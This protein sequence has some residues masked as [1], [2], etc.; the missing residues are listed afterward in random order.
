MHMRPRFIPILLSSLA[1]FMGLGLGGCEEVPVHSSLYLAI[2]SQ[3]AVDRLEIRVRTGAEGEWEVLG[4][5]ST[6]DLAIEDLGNKDLTTSPYIV[7]VDAS[8]GTG[9][10]LVHVVGW[11]GEQR[12]V[13]AQHLDLDEKT[14]VTVVLHSFSEEC[15]QD[16]D[17][18]LRCSLANCCGESW[19]SEE[20]SDCEDLTTLAHPFAETVCCEDADGDGFPD[21]DPA[22]DC[23][24]TAQTAHVGAIELCDG[25]DNDCNG[26]T[27]ELP[28]FSNLGAVCSAEV[29]AATLGIAC[30]GN[31]VCSADG[32]STVCAFTADSAAGEACDDGEACTKEDACTGGLNSQCVGAAYSC[33]EESDCSTRTCDG[34]GGCDIVVE[35][36]F[37]YDNEVCHPEGAQLGCYVCDAGANALGLSIAVN[38][39][40]CDDTNPC[41]VTDTCQNA[42]CAGVVAEEGA[43]CDDGDDCTTEEICVAGECGDGVD[44]CDDGNVCT[45]D[46]CVPD[47]G[48]GCKF[49][50]LEA[51]TSC[52]DD[53]ACTLETVC[54]GTSCEGGV[55]LN[56]DDGNQ[57]TSNACD[58]SAGCVSTDL[59]GVGCDD[60]NKCT[61]NDLCD[62]GECDGELIGP[63]CD[64]G[65]VCTLDECDPA[66]GCEH[67]KL[68]NTPCDDGDACTAVDTCVVGA[69]QSGGAVVCSTAGDTD[70]LTNLCKSDVGCELTP[71]NNG[72]NC[73]DGDLCT[74]NDVCDQG[75]CKG[76]VPLNCEDGQIC[77]LD[78]C[79]PAVGCAYENAVAG[80]IDGNPCTQGDQCENGVCVSGTNKDC[81]DGEICTTDGGC[82]QANG[83]C[84]YSNNSNSCDDGLSCHIG[85][86]CQNGSCQQGSFPASC[87]DG[88]DCTDDSCDDALGGCVHAPNDLACDDGVNCTVDECDA[89]SGCSYEP[90][91]TD[92][93]DGDGCTVDVCDPILGCEN[94]PEVNCCESESDCDDGDPCTTDTCEAGPG[95]ATGQCAFPAVECAAGY[96]CL[97][98]GD[99]FDGECICNQANCACPTTEDPLNQCSLGGSCL[100]EGVGCVD[101]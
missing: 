67:I 48:G 33:D 73:S 46:S 17:G 19:Y 18:Y 43:A 1:A 3:I 50:P 26:E 101:F 30:P 58:S 84:E 34:A 97:N 49:D 55:A 74:T 22:L 11:K 31:R 64:D 100:G 96:L 99:A 13:Y 75:T 45:V 95:S 57:C 80:C 61:E 85:D 88:L 14:Q 9:V 78:S 72:G 89:S 98:T 44:P 94:A 77:T 32:M 71:T 70:C 36:G 81:S 62:G 60:G 25:S 83:E 52:D 68:S 41:T 12:A 93:D 38:G 47:T 92:C 87:D 21:C 7:R 10:A 27:D 82:N 8:S 20:A 23:D 86:F 90:I 53:D 63:D 24:P 39:T 5:D 37:C 15:D 69:C 91:D 56:C 16:G 35:P 28:A 66:I 76:P 2:S 54:A 59:Q 42:V 29:M 79:D 4:P 6:P 40:D 51:G 65:L